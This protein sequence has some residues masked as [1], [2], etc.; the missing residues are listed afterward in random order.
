MS[1]HQGSRRLL[2]M[3]ILANVGLISNYFILGHMIAICCMW[4]WMPLDLD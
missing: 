1:G 4:N 2:M 3:P